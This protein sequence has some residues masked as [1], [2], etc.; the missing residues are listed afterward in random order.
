MRLN[1]RFYAWPSAQGAVSRSRLDARP[2][3]HASSHAHSYGA[4]HIVPPTD[5]SA[6]KVKNRRKAQ[7]VQHAL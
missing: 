7:L 4:R 2:A 3:R 6:E 1:F 5:T